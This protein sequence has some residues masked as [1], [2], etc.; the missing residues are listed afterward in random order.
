MRETTINYGNQRMDFQ[1]FCDKFEKSDIEPT[2]GD[3]ID[4][5]KQTNENNPALVPT[6]LNLVKIKYHFSFA[7]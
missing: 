5:L 6:I 2:R 3:L 1:Q 4:I 7:F